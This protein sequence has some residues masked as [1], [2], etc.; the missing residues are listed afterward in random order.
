MLKPGLG[1]LGLK[2][3][4]T[5]LVGFCEVAVWRLVHVP[6]GVGLAGVALA[7]ACSA[8]RVCFRAFV[9]SF[10]AYLLL[11][12]PLAEWMVAPVFLFLLSAEV[13]GADVRLSDPF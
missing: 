8:P 11:H 4:S 9:L 6:R 5:S 7:A 3:S 13:M 12:A 2:G 1:H 10:V